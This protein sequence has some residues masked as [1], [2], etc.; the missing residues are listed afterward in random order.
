MVR[1]LGDVVLLLVDD[2]AGVHKQLVR[3][4]SLDED[5][6]I[7]EDDIDVRLRNWRQAPPQWDCT[8]VVDDLDDA[9]NRCNFSKSGQE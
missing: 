1:P 8:M 2:S 7:L 4:D 6:D 5:S 3:P 9:E